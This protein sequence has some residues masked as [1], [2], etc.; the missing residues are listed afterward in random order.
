[1]HMSVIRTCDAI[2]DWAQY[3][4]LLL[5]NLRHN[6]IGGQRLA[7]YKPTNK[8]ELIAVTV[9]S[10][11]NG[12]WFQSD[13]RQLQYGF[14]SVTAILLRI[15]FLW[16][17]FQIFTVHPQ[18]DDLTLLEVSQS[19][20]LSINHLMLLSGENWNAASNK[21]AC[22]QAH[23]GVY[24]QPVQLPIFSSRAMPSPARFPRPRW[25]HRQQQNG[26]GRQTKLATA[27]CP[28]IR[29]LCHLKH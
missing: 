3:N 20:W 25:R 27:S 17:I 26:L 28:W 21:M 19:S 2:H 4:I 8:E 10:L 15:V 11:L 22:H 16:Y 1:M 23:S 13:T 29:E 9:F 14:L 7:L 5:F 12:Q 18:D 6:F 24:K